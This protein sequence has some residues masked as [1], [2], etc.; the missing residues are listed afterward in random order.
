MPKN[1]DHYENA[2]N[3]QVVDYQ[4]IAN[5]VYNLLTA[6]STALPTDLIMLTPVTTE[7]K[8]FAITLSYHIEITLIIKKAYLD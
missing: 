1:V 3:M 4:K 2:C 8:S 6:S 5:H 7:F